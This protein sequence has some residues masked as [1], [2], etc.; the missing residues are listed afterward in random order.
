MMCMAVLPKF[1]SILKIKIF[2]WAP[3]AH[4]CNPGDSRGREQEGG[5]SKPA[6]ANSWRDPIS[7]KPTTK[8]D[9]WGGSSGRVPVQQV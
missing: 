5:G 2:C 8:Q 9:Q 4:A 1:F 3:V 7:K 6:Q